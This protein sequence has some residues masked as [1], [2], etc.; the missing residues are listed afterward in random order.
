MSDA[1]SAPQQDAVDK[2]KTAAAEAVS[3]YP[4]SCS[5]AAWHVIKAFVP[6][7]PYRTANDLVNALDQDRRWKSVPVAE[8]AERA[9]RGELIVGGLKTNPNGHVIVVYPGQ[10]KP[11]GGYAY[12]SGGRS[13]TMRSRGM[14]ARAM[15]TSLGGWAGAKSNGDKTV[16]DSWANDAKFAEVKFWRLDTAAGQ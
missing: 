2:L 12:T 1:L 7:Q 4:A 11:A 15:S 8:L 3:K 10:P 16:W 13:Q 5:H 9:S 6:D 14:Y